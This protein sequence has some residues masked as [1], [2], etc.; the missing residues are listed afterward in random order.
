M[1][2]VAYLGVLKSNRFNIKFHETLKRVTLPNLSCS[3]NRSCDATNHGLR[4]SYEAW[5]VF[6]YLRSKGVKHIIEVVVPDCMVH[7]HAN[8]YI[9]A[10]LRPFDVR[11][12]KWRK[13]NL[14]VRTIAMA[15]PEVEQLT[16]YSSGDIDALYQWADTDGLCR[17]P[18]VVALQTLSCSQWADA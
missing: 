8:K 6:D 13:L 15:A 12:L 17:L 10:A 3:E 11:R 2:F 1:N 18:K 5:V 4:K 16:L 9:I 7:P 14:G